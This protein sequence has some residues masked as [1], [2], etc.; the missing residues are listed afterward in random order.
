M[1]AAQ[2]ERFGGP[3]VVRVV[4]LPAAG[5]GPGQVVVDV[6]GSSINPADIAVRSGWMSQFIPMEPPLTLGTDIAGIVTGL[7]DGVVNL[8]VGDSVY[9]AAG[10]VMG[11]SGGFAEQAVT[12]AG[13]LAIVPAGIDLVTAG[14]L[15]LA[16]IAALEGITER[17]N[18]EPG[19]RLL[20][21]GASGGVGLFA[22]ALAAHLGGQV[23][24]SVRTERVALMHGLGVDDVVDSGTTDLL[25]LEPF[26]LVLDLVGADP[27]LPVQLTKPG[28]RAVGLR[29][30]PDEE[31]AAAKGVEVVLQ[32]TGVTTERL[33]RFRDYVEQQVVRPY[34]AH[35]FELSDVSEAFT[36]KETV[37][38][39]GKIAI[40]VK[41]GT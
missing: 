25:S 12:A 37:G 14:A 28:G 9:G 7:G 6:V 16:G 33:D 36:M 29:I 32:A 23:V 19:S 5:V 17:L 10:I 11:G 2:I 40:A 31:A 18:V 24:A 27:A 26:D 22:V 38:A 4:D 13:Q 20:V 35:T 21:H 8:A 15:P 30:M 3:E 34:I 39:P 1:R 41:R